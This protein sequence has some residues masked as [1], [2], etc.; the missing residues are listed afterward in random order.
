MAD[1]AGRVAINE[2]DEPI[3]NFGKYKGKSVE[4]VFKA[5]PSKYTWMMNGDFTLDTKQV[6]TELKIK[7]DSNKL[8]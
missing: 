8:L 7:F 3:F 1:Y 2:K 4:S 6:I 5:D